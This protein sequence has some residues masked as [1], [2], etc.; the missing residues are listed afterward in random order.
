MPQYN[1][2]ALIV[3][4]GKGLRMGGERPKQY[5][6]LCGKTVLWH[7]VQAFL[8]HPLVDQ[9]LVVIHPEH[10]AMY[11]H[12]VAGLPV[13]P[14]AFAGDERQGSVRNGLKALQ[15]YQPNKVL[16]HDGARP[17]VSAEIITAV[18]ENTSQN[19]GAAPA[20]MVEDTLKQIEAGDLTETVDRT[21][22]RRIQTPQGFLFEEIAALHESHYKE[23]VT[24]DTALFGLAGKRIHAVCGSKRN[25]KVTDREDLAMAETML[26]PPMEY[27]TGQGFDVHAFCDAKAPQNNQLRLGGVDI[28]YEQSLSG[29]SDADVALHALTDAILGAIGQ[30]DIG[31]HF[32]PSDDT[33]KNMDSAVFLEKARQL[34]TDTRGKIVHVDITIICEAPRI[35]A[36]RDAMEARIAEILTIDISRVSV[37][38]TTTE[39]LGFTGRKEG[40]AAQAVATVATCGGI[41]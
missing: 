8:E 41:L 21:Q 29:H 9:V 28:P 38:A 6:P 5:M 2:I 16:I 24:D 40:I 30:K 37:K 39:K 11:D 34:V 7:S 14:V 15:A 3:A 18:I 17:C 12:A 25:I 36:Y 35:T 31:Y 22:L 13:L 33:F 32:P 20:V 27:R 23:A 26:N 10:Q 19:Q 4:G 1:I